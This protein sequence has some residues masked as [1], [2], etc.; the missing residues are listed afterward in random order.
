VLNEPP[1]RP[2]RYMGE[3]RYSSIILDFG[4]RRTEWLASRSGGFITPGKDHRYPL[5]WGWVDLRA[6]LDDVEKILS[7]TGTRIP[8]PR[9][10]SLYVAR[11]YTDRAIHIDYTG[12]P[13]RKG[14]Y[15]GRS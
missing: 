10:S 14:L 7:T 2:W 6:G 15:S 1:I 13:R 5:D 11:P 3:W 12:C 4:T 9:S 8:T